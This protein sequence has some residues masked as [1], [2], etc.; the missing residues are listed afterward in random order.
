MIDDLELAGQFEDAGKRA[1]A[2]AVIAIGTVEIQDV[3]HI[4]VSPLPSGDSVLRAVIV[5]KISRGVGTAI[6]AGNSLVARQ[7]NVRT[8]PQSV[9]DEYRR[10]HNP[11]PTG[12]F[13]IR[14][15]VH[16][17][18]V[19]TWRSEEWSKLEAISA[20][21]TIV[22]EHASQLSSEQMRALVAAIVEAGFRKS[23]ERA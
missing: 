20:L 8:W 15:G 7:N 1:V 16:P 14:L 19:D 11:A 10:Q 23:G 21:S 3:A 22:I 17:D 13:G 5:R 2:L 12:S 4:D 6:I 9:A 18:Q